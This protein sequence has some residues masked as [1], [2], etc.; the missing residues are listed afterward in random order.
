MKKILT[1]TLG[2]LFL[3]PIVV[4]AADSISSILQSPSSYDGKQVT[5]NGTIQGI[6]E[7][8]SRKGNAYDTFSI[9]DKECLHVFVFGHPSIA[10]GQRRTII[11]TFTAIKHVGSYTFYNEIEMENQ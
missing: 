10:E 1:F 5:V 11:G 6:R 4:L 9:C 2:I 7:K 8:V 3:A